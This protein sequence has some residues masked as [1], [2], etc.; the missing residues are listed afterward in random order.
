M[1]R[2]AVTGVAM[3]LVVVAAGCGGNDSDVT[4]ASPATTTGSGET[5]AFCNAW[6][7]AVASGDESTFDEVLAQPPPELEE[8]AAVVR[9]AEATGSESPQA[10]AATAEI[11]NWTELHCDRGEPRESQRRVAPPINAEFEGLAFCGTTAFPGSPSDDSSGMVLYGDAAADDAYDGPMLGV[12]WNPA[13][14]GGHRGDGDSEPVTVRGRSGVAAPI[15]VF[16]QTILPEL[17]SVI[18]WAE[19]D[20]EL[21][22]YGRGWSM[23]RA[24]ELVAIADRLEEVETG[25][26]IPVDALPQGYTEVFTGK[27]SVASL[28]VAPSP[29][30]FLR[31]QGDDGLL[32]VSGLQMSEEEFEAFRFFTIGVDKAEVAGRQGLVGNAWHAEGPSVVTWRDPD[33]LVV[34]I[35][36][37]GVPLEIA[38]QGAD[39]SRELT[40]EEWRA[41]VEADDR[42]DEGLPQP[43]GRIGL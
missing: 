21:G 31:Y 40:D 35:V 23:D 29:L 10:E 19:G 42:C 28:V 39:E 20:R 16:Q 34:R 18:A 36:G 32:M 41:L 37:I 9:E 26:G 33:G 24:D 12:F 7:A 13:E 1:H 22:L 43:P 4:A 3:T 5:A 30:Y 11:L 2:Q 38:R 25:F 17:G 27:S 8:A 6:S 15:T 14:D